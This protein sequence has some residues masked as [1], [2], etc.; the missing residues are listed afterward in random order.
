L[1]LLHELLPAANTIALLANPGNV[2]VKT[3]EPKIR[4]AADR[5]KKSP[6][7]LTARTES[8]LEAAFA[9]MV[10]HASAA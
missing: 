10:Q 7:V 2:N 1:E 4:A 8:D 3:D 9:T 5:L 6:E